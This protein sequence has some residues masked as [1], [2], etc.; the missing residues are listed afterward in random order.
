MSYITLSENYIKNKILDEKYPD[1]QRLKLEI[2]YS[3][4]SVNRLNQLRNKKKIMVISFNIYCT[5]K[6]P[7]P[8]V[9]NDTLF[10]KAIFASDKN[11][12]AG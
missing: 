6:N 12:E 7:S 9:L 2:K 4:K 8:P 1:F 11:I 10:P 5:V 3:N